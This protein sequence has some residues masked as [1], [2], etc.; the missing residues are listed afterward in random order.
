MLLYL[1]REVT[2]LLYIFDRDMT[3]K[4][5]CNNIGNSIPY[6]NDN[7][8]RILETGTDTY[9][10]T[11]PS[12]AEGVE[13]ILGGNYVSLKDD[14]NKNILFTIRKTE[15]SHSDKNEIIVT[16]D[17]AGMELINEDA[18]PFTPTKEL[19]IQEYV[20]AVIEGTGWV[21][22]EDDVSDKAKIEFTNTG[23][24]KLTRLQ[25]IAQEFGIYISFE[26]KFNSIG[27][28]K[29]YINLHTDR[30]EDRG[31]RF[32]FTKDIRSVRR[33]VEMDTVVSAIRGY[34]LADKNGKLI[35]LT[36]EEFDD[37]EYFTEKGGGYVYS[38]TTE[39]K[40]G[41]YG[42]NIHRT[43]N[44]DVTSVA[45]LKKKVLAELKARREPS[46][47][48]EVDVALL[49]SIDEDETKKVRIGD[50]VKVIDNTFEP[51]LLLEA[52]VIQLE[53][54]YTDPS[55]NKCV[56]GNYKVKKSNISAAIRDIQSK[57]QYNELKWSSDEV[58]K[59][60]TEPLDPVINDLWL[61]T[62]KQPNILYR[63]DGASWIPASPTKP[64]D[65]G[66]FPIEEGNGLIEQVTQMVDT[67][68]YSEPFESILSQ[69]ANTEDLS[70]MATG[71]Q[72]A[73]VRNEAIQYID[74]RIDGEGGINENINR[75]SS[76]LQKTANDIT[77]KFSSSGGINLVEN[78]IGYAGT[79]LWN[80]TGTMNTV[81]NLELE[82][83]GF[84]CGWYSPV[85]STGYIEQ[86]IP[87]KLGNKHMLSFWL[88]KLRD[89]TSEAW[90][91]IEI[92]AGGQKLAFIGKDTNQGITYGTNGDGWEL[93]LYSFETDLDTATIRV[94]FGVNTEA[95]I[96]GLMINVGDN[97]LQWQHANG[98]V[99]NT[100][101][102]MNLNG[103]KVISEDYEGYTIM[104]P[105]EF[106][107]YAIVP[108]EDNVPV[109]TKVFTLNKDVTEVS[110]IDV[111]KE[112]SM[113]GIKIIPIKSEKSNGWAFIST[114]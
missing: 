21:I 18:N 19:T 92:Y 104:S 77:A 63:Y 3:L 26:I 108:N 91:G 85:G 34:G 8:V 114:S 35:N 78:S 76:E 32:E 6:Y 31:N 81:Q 74:G 42:N 23:D 99:Y 109:M 70:D 14:D 59:S 7:H 89:N 22:G 111:D 40:Y 24:S 12:Q 62:S 47:V 110:K 66:A 105:Q 54:S 93:G 67:V 61:D 15:D 73:E 79:D 94:T 112:I 57:L 45:A 82:K 102:Q 25:Q 53:I 84:G 13:H 106:S 90:A 4:T 86:T 41:Q 51:P 39:E 11:V 38:R 1:F 65:V 17:L 2:R 69:K 71:E 49:E 83:L 20:E 68:V 103:L 50:T 80:V 64:E 95:I 5:V 36:N 56:L 72:L 107:G 29:K 58:E 16:C 100:S 44:Y 30:G 101:V 27:I 113:S 97:Y 9:T 37:G 55:R 88:K 33:T 87:T 43:Y 98:E 10:F 75:V 52:K 96:S 48:Y 46:Y 28:Q 60:D